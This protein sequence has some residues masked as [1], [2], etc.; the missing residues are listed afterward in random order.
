MRKKCRQS[1]HRRLLQKRVPTRRCQKRQSLKQT[2]PKKQELSIRPSNSSSMSPPHASLERRS[3]PNKSTTATSSPMTQKEPMSSP[4][5]AVM[6]SNSMPIRATGKSKRVKP[7]RWS[8]HL[9]FTRPSRTTLILSI[10]MPNAPLP[11]WY[12]AA[13]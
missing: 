13:A 4:G 7:W 8:M 5:T 6:S 11:P 3:L 9:K 10:S 1:R 2:S 12:A